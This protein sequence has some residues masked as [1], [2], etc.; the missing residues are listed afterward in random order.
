[1][2]EFWRRRQIPICVADTHMA[3][4]GRELGQMSLDIDAVLVSSQQRVD[5]HA[6]TKIVQPWSMGIAGSP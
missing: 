3:E 4:I 1:M 2:Q 6:V 5:G